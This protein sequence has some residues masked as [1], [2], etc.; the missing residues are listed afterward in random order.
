M[1]SGTTGINTIRIYNPVKQGYDH[2]PAGRFVRAH[3]P[4]LAC[5]PDAFVHE[6][7][8]WEGA[9]SLQYPAPIVD[10][11]TAAKAARD[12]LHGIRKG[13]DHK[14]V[15]RQIVDKHGSRKT[16]M[17]MTGAKRGTRRQ[18][19]PTAQLALDL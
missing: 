11:A 16:G 5:V 9:A 6:P 15:A 7:W 13:A 18:P 4:E 8:S 3:V 1:Q 14:T 12:A 17:L 2:D 10:N 19:A